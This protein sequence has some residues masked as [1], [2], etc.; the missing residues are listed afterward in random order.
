MSAHWSRDEEEILAR[1]YPEHGPMWIGYESILP[2]R[3]AQS[4]A[5]K[6]RRMGIASMHCEH[7]PDEPS[8]LEERVMALMADGMTTSEIDMELGLSKGKAHELVVSRWNG[9]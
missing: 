8:E 2:G 9:G 7:M 5:T 6:A 3:T 1:T 4:I